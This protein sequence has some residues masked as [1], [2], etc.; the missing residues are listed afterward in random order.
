MEGKYVNIT[1]ELLI[2]AGKMT[3]RLVMVMNGWLVGDR[4]ESSMEVASGCT[5]TKFYDIN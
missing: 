3:P 2:R 1:M 5:G 4:T